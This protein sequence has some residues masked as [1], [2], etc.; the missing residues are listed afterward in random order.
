[1]ETV[2]YIEVCKHTFTLAGYAD[3]TKVRVT[4]GPVCCAIGGNPDGADKQQV[5]DCRTPEGRHLLVSVEDSR[6]WRHEGE[7]AYGPWFL[8]LRGLE[9]HNADWTGIAIHGTHQPDSLG[10]KASHGCVRLHNDAIDALHSLVVPGE[11][12]V[13]ILA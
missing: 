12:V 9:P 7:F 5:G 3:E 8:R 10:T 4:F 13:V 2:R 6:T 1:M 11:T